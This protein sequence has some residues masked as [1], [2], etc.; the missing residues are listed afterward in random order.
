MRQW[1]R[2]CRAAMLV[3]AAAA[4]LTGLAAASVPRAVLA[5]LFTADW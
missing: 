4:I 2:L 3:L 5:E 1:R